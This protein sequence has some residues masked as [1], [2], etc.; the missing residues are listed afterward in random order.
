[1]TLPLSNNKFYILPL[2]QTQEQIE[3]CQ[4]DLIALG[5][6]CTHSMN[7]ATYILTCLKSPIRLQRHIK[8]PICPV[9]H[10]KWILECVTRNKFIDPTPYQIHIPEIKEFSK[11]DDNNN[12]KQSSQLKND[13]HDNQKEDKSLKR[14]ISTQKSTFIKKKRPKLNSQGSYQTSGESSLE[15]GDPFWENMNDYQTVTYACEL[16]SPLDY[17]NKDLVEIFEFL[18]HSRE[19]RGDK[20]NSLSYRKA[21]TAIK[22]Y[23]FQIKSAYEAIQLKG[24]GKKTGKIIENYLKN[25]ET[26]EVD[27]VKNDAQ[28]QVM[29]KF[30]KIHGVGASTAREWYKK[31]YRTIEDLK[32]NEKLSKDQLLGIKYYDD[33]LQRIPRKEVEL[34]VDE[35]SKELNQLQPDCEYTVCGSYR[36]GKSTCGDVDIVITHRD[37][38]V[39]KGLLLKLVNHLQ[40]KGHIQD[41]LSI[42]S[43]ID[44]YSP[45]SADQYGKS[46]CVWLTK[47]EK[48]HRRVDL[49]VTSWNEYPVGVLAWTGSQYFERSLRLRAKKVNGLKVNSRGLFRNG[50]KL[51]VKN[52]KQIF[53]ILGLNYLEPKDRN[54]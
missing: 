41:I 40:S 38:N 30:Y 42:S 3:S 7:K 13:Q 31:G 28:Y 47:N 36:R 46:L 53:E 1:M 6:I 52:E 49:I 15:Q 22:S 48:I 34:I 43:E 4:K 50:Q 35:F 45:T 25:G 19:L 20:M 39:T 29:E 5:G 24:I 2:K 16:P 54:C 26:P 12:Q 18:E 23:P 21:I 27:L 37:D 32:M 44:P 11:D 17:K 51:E 8:N 33:F 10:T 9:V 14:P